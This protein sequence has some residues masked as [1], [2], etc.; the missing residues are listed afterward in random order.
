HLTGPRPNGCYTSAEELISDVAAIRTSLLAEG[1]TEV[2]EQEVQ[3]WIDQIQVFG[4]HTARLD[5]RQHSA[6][7]RDVI[8]ELWQAAGLIDSRSSLTEADRGRLL[9]VPIET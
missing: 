2:A 4:L 6:V 9:A 5:I 3:T 1:N 8:S 7:Y